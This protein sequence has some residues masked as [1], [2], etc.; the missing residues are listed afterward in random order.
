MT[1]DFNYKLMK[2]LTGKIVKENGS[3][4]EVIKK[5]DE[6]EYSDFSSYLPDNWNSFNFEDI[7]N[8]KITLNVILYGGYKDK[9]NNSGGIIMVLSQDFKPLNV[10]YKYENGTSLR[11]I[12]AL[13]QADDG[14][15]YMLD[16]VGFPEDRVEALL[17]EG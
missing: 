7:V 17:E 2:Y 10:F 6:I 14:T 9:N 13:N 11:Y 4:D 8:D 3:N 12:M 5:I 15:F 1:Q 16:C